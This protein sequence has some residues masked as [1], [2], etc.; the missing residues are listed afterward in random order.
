LNLP[1]L[2]RRKSFYH[3]NRCD[4]QVR[5]PE[6]EIDSAERLDLSLFGKLKALSDSTELAEVL[7]KGSPAGL[8]AGRNKHEGPKFK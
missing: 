6:H 7:S 3:L 4:P 2:G 8:V 1:L 5:N